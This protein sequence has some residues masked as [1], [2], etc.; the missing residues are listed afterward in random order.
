MTLEILIFIGFVMGVMKGIFY[1][2]LYFWKSKS[3]IGK[4]FFNL[5]ICVLFWVC[6]TFYIHVPPPKEWYTSVMQVIIMLA[7]GYGQYKIF[8]TLMNVGVTGVVTYINKKGSTTTTNDKTVETTETT[9][10]TEPKP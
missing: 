2:N 7:L 9:K 3:D 5:C 10:V 4:T 1:D 8:N 6:L